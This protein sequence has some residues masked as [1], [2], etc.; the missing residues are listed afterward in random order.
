[1]TI[2]HLQSAVLALG[3]LLLLATSVAS[4]TTAATPLSGEVVTKTDER[5]AQELYED[6]N[7]YLGRKYAEFNKQKLGYDTQLEAKTKQ[8]QKALAVANAAILARRK[9]HLV[10]PLRDSCSVPQ[11]CFEAEVRGG[12][13]YPDFDSS[14]LPAASLPSAF[15]SH[16]PLRAA[17]LM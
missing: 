9:D 8:E 6:A 2:R 14:T 5:P 4:Q 13:T 10:A 15:S 11:Q 12:M 16:I 3:S 1:M 7:G 17:R